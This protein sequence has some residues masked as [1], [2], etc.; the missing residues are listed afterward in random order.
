MNA[1]GFTQSDLAIGMGVSQQ[2]VSEWV[3]GNVQRPKKWKDIAFTL[4]IPM[5]EAERAVNTP[6]EMSTPGTFE[7]THVRVATFRPSPNTGRQSRLAPPPSGMIPVM[8]RAAA[9]EPGKILL[10]DGEPSEWIPCPP[11]LV[12]VEGAYATYVYGDSMEPRYFNGERV[13]VHPTRPAGPKDFVV[14]QVR[15]EA[16]NLSG[17]VKRLLG[18]TEQGLR[19]HQYN[20]E[21]DLDFEPDAVESVHLVVGSGRG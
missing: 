8:G 16:G 13:Y 21:T 10:L 20:P 4:G 11:E 15:D 1:K 19:L 5:E 3:N 12:G 14:A 7:Q 18:W 9:G 17:Y 2:A 6:L